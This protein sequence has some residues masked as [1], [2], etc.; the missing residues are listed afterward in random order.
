MSNT[1]TASGYKLTD[2]TWSGGSRRRCFQRHIILADELPTIV[3]HSGAENQK[4]I[5]EEIFNFDFLDD[6]EEFLANNGHLPR[7]TEVSNVG[8]VIVTPDAAYKVTG[9]NYQ[10]GPSDVYFDVT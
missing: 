7:I 2:G 3:T 9:F 1:A 8:D 10:D 4:Y 5:V 6:Y